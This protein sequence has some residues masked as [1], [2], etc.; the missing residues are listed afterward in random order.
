VSP[1]R[2]RP[3]R[4]PAIWIVAALLTA[5]GAAAAA[6]VQGLTDV[7]PL[8]HAYDQILDADFDQAR[9][10]LQQACPPAPAEACRTLNA[11]ADWWRI[12]LDPADRSRDAAFTQAADGA[13]AADRAWTAREPDR[14]EAWFY[15]G[16]AYATRVQWQVLRGQRLAAARDGNR[17]REALE[18]AVQLDPSLQDAYFGIGLYHYYAAVAPLGARLLRWLLM[19]PGGNRAQGL[20]EMQ[21]TRT[22]G[23]LL[24]GE[25]DYQL[26]FIY[27][28]Y[29][30][31][32]DGALKLLEALKARYPR[33]PLFPAQIASVQDVYLHDYA[34]SAATD[35]ALIAAAG[36]HAVNFPE[37]AEAGA[38]F[39]LAVQLDALGRTGDAARTLQEV[40][41]MRPAAPYSVLARAHLHLGRL[42]D[43]TDQHARAAQQYRA[44]IASTPDGDPYHVRNRARDALAH[45]PA[46]R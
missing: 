38:R 29:Q 34:A 3:L 5:P 26:H 24:R 9:V 4:G 11:V 39:H 16:G 28:W 32:T 12:S 13:I 45:E 15:L 37:L 7:A 8:A 6:P 20:R 10:T 42:Y 19:L 14:A 40:I 30:H 33:D 43:R 23:Q 25:A 46:R 17:I 41:A 2:L 44:A 27:L 18:H 31:D 35:E 1:G 21:R 22:L 36:A